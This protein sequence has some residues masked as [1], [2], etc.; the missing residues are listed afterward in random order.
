MLV[1][2]IHAANGTVI[3]TVKGLSFNCMEVI[4]KVIL[5]VFLLFSGLSVFGQ[6]KRVCFTFDDLPV[7]NYAVTDTA[8]LR[9]IS[10]NLIHSLKKN[11]IPAIGFVNEEK[12]YDEN[13]INDFQVSLLRNWVRGGFDLG[14]HTYSHPDFNLVSLKVFSE[15]VLKGETISRQLLA[16]KGKKLV[17]FRHPFLHVGNNR[18]KADS[19]RDFLSRQGYTVAPVTIDNE[20]YLFALAYQR[21]KA[22]TDTMLMRQIGHDYLGYMAMKMKYFGNQAKI[23]FGREIPQILLLHAS[24]LNADYVDALANVFSRN[25]YEFISLRKALEDKMYESP[26]T[27]YGNWGISWIDRWAL[28]MGKKGN[29]F[30][31]EPETPG[32]IQKLA[33]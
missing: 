30:K 1:R 23:L 20:D 13:G 6:K 24:N 31:E 32:Y 21:A 25:G 19:L 11:H 33:E 5:F 2:N 28:S 12:C 4:R 14:N 29:F 27:V 7:V 18:V 15:N 16:E 9:T 22:K 3:E 17:Y 10:D 8:S 26:I